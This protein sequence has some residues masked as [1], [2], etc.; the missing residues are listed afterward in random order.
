MKRIFFAS[1]IAM[2]LLVPQMLHAQNGIDKKSVTGSWLGK[3]N[4]GA[5][6]LR[7]I[8]NCRYR[9]RQSDSDL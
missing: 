7:I 9:K 3:I 2:L 4:T 5:L 1:I 6:E 8:F